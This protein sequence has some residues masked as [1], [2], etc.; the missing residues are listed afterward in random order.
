[1]EECN[2][3]F[4]EA[5]PKWENRCV[6]CKYYKR[7]VCSKYRKWIESSFRTTCVSWRYFF[8]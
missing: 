8:E 7:K 5:E 4:V 3:E 1:M 6:S 2:V